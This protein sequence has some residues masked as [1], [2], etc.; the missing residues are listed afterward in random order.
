MSHLLYKGDVP[1]VCERADWRKCPEHK[2][3][4]TK[5]PK[6]ASNPVVGEIE[7]GED[8]LYRENLYE[9]VISED[10]FLEKSAN[11]S[12]TLHLGLH[13]DETIGADWDRLTAIFGD[14]SAGE[15]YNRNDVVLFKRTGVHDGMVL[16]DVTYERSPFG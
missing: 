4:T 5:K 3:L 2:F 14:M 12:F 11:G 9:T 1:V 7:S 6:F 10:E 16:F 13:K 15:H 8:F